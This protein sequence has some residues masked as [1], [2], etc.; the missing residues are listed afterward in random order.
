[1]R[2]GGRNAHSEVAAGDLAGGGVDVAE[3]P[4]DPA[5]EPACQGHRNGE[6]DRSDRGQDQPVAAHSLVNLRS[7]VGDAGGAVDDAAGGDRHRHV[8][9]VGA[10]RARELVV[11]ARS[12]EVDA[13]EALGAEQHPE[14]QEQQQARNTHAVGRLR[15]EQAHGEQQAGDQN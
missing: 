8:E 9:E 3:R 6:H 2:A 11:A 7:R 1:M 5:R 4:H 14:A 13:P 15:R 10:E 12:A